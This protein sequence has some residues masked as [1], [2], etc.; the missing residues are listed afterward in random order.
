MKRFLGKAKRSKGADSPSTP[1]DAPTPASDTTTLAPTPSFAPSPHHPMANYAQQPLRQHPQQ[2]Y[3]QH[4]QQIHYGPDGQAYALVPLGNGP[5]HLAQTPRNNSHNSLPRPPR[6]SDVGNAIGWSC[7]MPSF[8]WGYVLALADYLSQ[9][10]KNR[11]GPAEESAKALRKEFKHAAPTAQEKAVRLM[12]LLARNS[13]IKFRQQIASKKFLSEL[14]DLVASPKTDPKVKE[15]VFR[16]LSPLSYD[17]QNDPTLSPLTATFAKLLTSPQ[18]SLTSFPN[19]LDPSSP[20]FTPPGAPLMEDD[21]LLRPSSLFQSS[22]SSS[23]G[24]SRRPRGVERLPS[25]R[26]QMERLGRR[27]V[28]GR[29]YAGML[30]EAVQNK[31][32]EGAEAIEADEIVQVRV[33]SLRSLSERLSVDSCG[34]RMEGQRRCA[35]EFYHKTLEA[36]ELLAAELEW[37]SVQAEQSRARAEAGKAEAGAPVAGAAEGEAAREEGE[38]EGEE[39]TVEERVFGTM[40]SASEEI[41]DSLALYHR[42]LTSHH[43]AQQEA[44]DLAAATERSKAD[45][46]FDRFAAEHAAGGHEYERSRDYGEGG[47]GAAGGSSPVPPGEFGAPAQAGYDIPAFDGFD[48]IRPVGGAPP[49]ASPAA[50]PADKGKGKAKRESLNPYAA[51]MVPDLTPTAPALAQGQQADDTYGGLDMFASGLS[52]GGSGAGGSSASSPFADPSA[53]PALPLQHH[54]QQQP[55]PKFSSSNPYAALSL[56]HSSSPSTGPS[57]PFIDPPQAV[58]PLNPPPGSAETE[59]SFLRQY[60]PDQPSEKAL[61]KLRRV[62]VREDSSPADVAA[63][64]DR[65]EAALRDKYIRQYEEEQERRRHEGEGER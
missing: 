40:L 33:F 30:V 52:L 16:V 53:A 55:Q 26:Q 54:Q 43:H 31:Q 22:H 50:A 3:N 1:P 8:D 4:Q 47:S 56:S 13:D 29:G 62:S 48:A 45:T 35:S 20:S 12:F 41:T 7:A 38:G 11:K 9:E 39:M 51:F 10:G 37:A 49:V 18:T 6:L 19:A 42:L 14:T 59:S 57:S 65:L 64:Q 63:Q 23:R 44:A 27:A 28:E 46:R 2:H 5:H 34:S 61:G 58:S 17:F 15:T 25:E 21:D 32:G 60:V 24:G 36:Q